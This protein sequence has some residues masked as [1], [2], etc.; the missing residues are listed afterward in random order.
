[1]RRSPGYCINPVPFILWRIE[2]P[3]RQRGTFSA[4]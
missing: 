1:M 4:S 2:L 3:P